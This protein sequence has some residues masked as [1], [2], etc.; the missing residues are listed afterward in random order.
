MN[1]IYCYKIPHNI[2][3][4]SHFKSNYDTDYNKITN[5]LVNRSKAITS[6]PVKSIVFK[7]QILKRITQ[8]YITYSLYQT[9]TGQDS[10]IEVLFKKLILLDYL[11]QIAKI[12]HSP[13]SF[14][15]YRPF[16]HDHFRLRK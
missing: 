15:L 5:N 10:F 6:D 2:I 14:H 1:P 7:E 4:K 12:L 11:L 9:E 8:W 3:V 16:L 13:V